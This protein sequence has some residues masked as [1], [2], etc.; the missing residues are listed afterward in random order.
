[1]FNQLSCGFIYNYIYIKSIER[2]RRK[3]ERSKQGQTNNKAK[4]HSTPMYMYIHVLLDEIPCTLYSILSTYYMMLKVR[5]GN[6]S[7]AD[8]TRHNTN[9]PGGSLDGTQTRNHKFFT[10]VSTCRLTHRVS[11]KALVDPRDSSVGVLEAAASVLIPGPVSEGGVQLNQVTLRREHEL[12]GVA[13]DHI[14]CVK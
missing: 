7:A 1:M 10:N 12:G 8:N 3:E 5:Q 14:L 6:T 13:I 9:N 11:D 4:Q 2:C